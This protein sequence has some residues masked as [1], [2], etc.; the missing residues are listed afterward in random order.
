MKSVVSSG[1]R[2][3]KPN[4]W[5]KTL[6]V[7]CSSQRTERKTLPVRK[8]GNQGF[9]CAV[10]GLGCVG[11][12]AY[13]KGYETSEAQA[14]AMRVFDR[15]AQFED[16]MLD[17]SDSYGPYTNEQLIR[18]I[19]SSRLTTTKRCF[20]ADRATIGRKGRF[21][22]ATRCG[23]VHVP[24]GITLNSSS[25]FIKKSCQGLPAKR[26]SPPESMFASLQAPWSDLEW[27]ASICTT[28]TATTGRRRSRRRWV[29]SK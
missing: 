7:S 22:I 19:L 12:S 29:P 17:T 6:R 9:K 13:Y 20:V 8:C 24:Q 26:C 11:M 4:S 23:S 25:E 14:E 21:R 18:E 28:S 3:Y 16:L 2:Y 10:Q 15:A 1:R 5:K 27:T